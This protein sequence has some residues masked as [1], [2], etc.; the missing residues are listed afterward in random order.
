M[1]EMKKQIK[2]MHEVA[3]QAIP[4][5]PKRYKARHHN[6]IRKAFQISERHI[7][8]LFWISDRKTFFGYKNLLCNVFVC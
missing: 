5:K 2:P 1:E 3:V 6:I 7:R 4:I 8:K